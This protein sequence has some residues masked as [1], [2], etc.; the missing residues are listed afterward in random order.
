M[1]EILALIHSNNIHAAKE[2]LFEKNVVDIAEEFGGGE[3]PNEMVLLIFR[4]LQKD[5]AAEVFAYLEPEL[6]GYIIEAFTDSEIRAIIDQL[7]LDDAVD[8]IEEMPANIVKRILKNTDSSTRGL[9]NQYLKYPEN[10]A[11]SLMTIEFVDL[12]KHFTVQEALEQIRRTG[13]DKETINTCYVI[14]A[15]RKLLGVIGIR[16]LILSGA[17][18][19]VGD[20]M[21]TDVVF[22]R[23]LDD[24][25]AVAEDFKKYDL[26]SMPVVDN[27]ERLVGIITID[28]I[29]DIIEQENTEDIHKMA[30]L[31]PSEDPYLRTGVFTLA[32][33]R[34]PWLLI[35]MVS[36]TFSGAVIGRFQDTLTRVVI[37]AAYI[38]MLMDSGGN[39][40]NQSSTLIIR[41]LALGEVGARDIWRVA[42]KEFL[43]SL[44]AG[45][46][47]AV[48]SFL[49]VIVLDGGALP[50]AVTVAVSL[51][52]TVIFAKIIGGMLPLA[53]KAV[54]LD[55][56]IMAS[57]LITTIVDAVALFVY[58]NLA[59]GIMKLH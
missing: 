37:L 30:A 56:A 49:K 35:L 18:E 1:N 44:I 12:K 13:I 40:G 31:S 57:P 52:L 20:L 23:T 28:D 25:E 8:L 27:E 2:L 50:L 32:K 45:A 19:A 21:Q 51:Y 41:S 4:L 39:S 36:A 22:C 26:L 42:R 6:Q 14:D 17:D 38:P 46:C 43:V 58:F 5:M 55:P 47:L 48:G 53:A 24:Q 3:I 10:S 15:S 29:V 9:I 16:R 33:N 59:V 34:I 54:R 7:F 11:G